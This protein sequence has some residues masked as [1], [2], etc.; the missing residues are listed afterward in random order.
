MPRP[1]SLAA[2]TLLLA[3][4]RLLCDR[5]TTI[6]PGATSSSRTYRVG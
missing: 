2:A 4:F 3:S 1:L 6:G 5:Q